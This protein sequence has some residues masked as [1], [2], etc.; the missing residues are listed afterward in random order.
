[1]GF[2]VEVVDWQGCNHVCVWGDEIMMSGRQ[3]VVMRGSGPVF[4]RW[5]R[6]LPRGGNNRLSLNIPLP[7]TINFHHVVIILNSLYTIS[8]CYL[9]VCLPFVCPLKMNYDVEGKRRVWG[10]SLTMLNLSCL[11]ISLPLYE[12]SML[13]FSIAEANGMTVIPTHGTRQGEA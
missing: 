4:W 13:V 11:I 10:A 5:W 6:E 9:V 12:K 7:P 1:M 3:V 8:I 2:A